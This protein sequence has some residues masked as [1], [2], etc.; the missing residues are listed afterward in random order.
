MNLKKSSLFL[1]LIFFSSLLF[2]QSVDTVHV[3]LDAALKMALSE[4]PT[5]RIANRDVQI[6]KYYKKEQIVSMF[7]SVSL[8]G[9]YSRTIQKQKMAMDMGGQSMEIEVGTYNN[10]SGAL[11]LSLPLVSPAQWYNLKLSQLDVEL[12]LE[13]ARQSDIAL[14]NEVRKAY[15]GYLFAKESYSVLLQN[16]TNVELN[17]K[18]ISEKFEQGI[19]SEFDKIRAE[20]Q[21]KNQKPNL[22]SAQNAVNLS[23]LMLKVVIGLD[24]D[25]PIIFDGSLSDFENQLASDGLN[26]STSS[27]LDSNEN[28]VQ[29]EYAI[30]QL[31]LARKIVISSSSPTLA[32]IG[33]ASLTSMNNDFKFSQYTWFPYSMVGLSLSIPLTSWASTAYQ[34]KQNRLNMENLQDQKIN[35]QRNLR[36]SLANN[37]NIIDKAKEDYLS[38]KETVMQAQRA[39]DIS[40][41]QYEIGMA[42]WLDLSSAEL[43]LTSAKL[44]FNQ[45][46]YDYISSLSDLDV[47][48]G[49][50]N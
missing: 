7:P 48:L 45:S 27:S 17:Y 1:L 42:T 41:K 30:K 32:F 2:S 40:L 46:V 47:V 44:T 50:T 15:Y 28:I 14:K 20:V 4:S 13:T 5:M 12:A 31:E 22:T 37:I 11:E 33:S 19:V 10:Y 36:V 3:N 35:L 43:A 24:I 16:Y 39:Y 34:L 9:T 49:K 29:L 21:L 38:N 6:K 8:S 23:L 18:N 26:V 25:E